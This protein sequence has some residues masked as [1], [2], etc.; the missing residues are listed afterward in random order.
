MVTERFPDV[1]DPKIGWLSDAIRA[2]YNK[3]ETLAEVVAVMAGLCLVLCIAALYSLASHYAAT[4]AREI[5]L[6]RVLGAGKREISQLFLRKMLLP[7]AI[8]GLL[9]LGP[10]WWLMAQWITKFK[11][12]APLPY[13]AYALA[14]VLVLALAAAMLL[15]HV[16]RVLKLRPASVLYHE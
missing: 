9:A 7:V 14:L 12:Q 10:I 16:R 3:S 13:G 15:G 2:H 5:A 6:R 11:D 4:R 8:G 1:N